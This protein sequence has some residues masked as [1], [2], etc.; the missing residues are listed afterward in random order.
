ML[1]GVI[2]TLVA[3]TAFSRRFGGAPCCEH[4]WDMHPPHFLLSM[5]VP[6]RFRPSL[7]MLLAAIFAGRLQKRFFGDQV[8]TSAVAHF[9]RPLGR[10][11]VLARASSG[12]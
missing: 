4:V 11:K 1:D 12:I 9:S 5:A 10:G 2:R 8:S 6:C 3:L 7:K